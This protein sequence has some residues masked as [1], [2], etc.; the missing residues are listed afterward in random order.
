MSG[1]NEG[2]P[3]RRMRSTSKTR[4]STLTRRRIMAAARE[5]MIERGSTSLQMGEVAERCQLSKGGLYYY[6]A[7]CDELIEAL[8]DE[9]V[10]D[11]ISGIEAVTAYATSA[12]DALTRLFEELARKLR[13]GGPLTLALIH[14]LSRS[15]DRSMPELV[16]R[17]ARLR[18]AIA[19][20]IEG[21][22]D[23]GLISPEVDSGL[24]AAYAIGGLLAVSLGLAGTR[25][26]EDP[27]ALAARQLDMMLWGLVGDDVDRIG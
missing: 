11:L 21:A 17:L 8:L 12:H 4:K 22:Q 15:D 1:G 14:E 9:S 7:D 2:R 10:D 3:D 18:R 25:A 16:G 27:E 24:A 6:F 20:Q 19:S 23:E 5:L 26:C 13:A